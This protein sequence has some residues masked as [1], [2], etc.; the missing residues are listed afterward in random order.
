MALNIAE[1]ALGP[2]WFTAK[3]CRAKDLASQ[4]KVKY[5]S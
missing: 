3:I 1:V 5:L 2:A 4:S